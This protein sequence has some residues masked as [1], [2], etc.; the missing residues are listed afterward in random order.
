MASF[1]WQ[2]FRL[3]NYNDDSKSCSSVCIFVR[4]Y[5]LHLSGTNKVL[6]DSK[7][8]KVK[9]FDIDI[10]LFNQLYNIKKCVIYSRS[11]T[12]YINKYVLMARRHIEKYVHHKYFLLSRKS[13]FTHFPDL[14]FVFLH[15]LSVP[16]LRPIEL[17]NWQEQPTKSYNVKH[18]TALAHR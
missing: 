9:K 6:K 5:V 14:F 2:N 11:C 17:L 4:F 12:I 13:M 15:I 7:C 10:K 3:H 8:L 18:D 16:I 1:L